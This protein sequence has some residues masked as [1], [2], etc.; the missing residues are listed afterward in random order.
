VDFISDDAWEFCKDLTELDLRSNK[1]QLL[2][3][4]A[5]AKLPS[6]RRLYLQVRLSTY[7]KLIRRLQ[8][9]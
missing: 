8:M 1:L 5:L 6:L 4:F 7:S 3:R 9:D 2:D